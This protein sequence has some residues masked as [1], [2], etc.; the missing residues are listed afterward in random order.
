M[1]LD[2]LYASEIRFSIVTEWDAGYRVRLGSEYGGFAATATVNTF[3]EAY[4]RLARLA[5][6]HYRASTLRKRG[7]TYLSCSES[8]LTDSVR[9]D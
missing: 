6:Q 7:R 2:N 8:D 5:A 4:E 3:A 1:I 9:S